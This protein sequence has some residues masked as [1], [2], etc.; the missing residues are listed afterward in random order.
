MRFANNLI[1]ILMKYQ[2]EE[3]KDR[4]ISDGANSSEITIE[5]ICVVKYI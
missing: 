5:T 4:K 1:N 3:E 2:K